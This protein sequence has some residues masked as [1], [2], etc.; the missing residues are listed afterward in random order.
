MTSIMPMTLGFTDAMASA[1]TGVG[2]ICGISMIRGTRDGMTPGI[3]VTA[4]AITAGTA[5]GTTAGA[6]P[7]IIGTMAIMDGAIL[8]MEVGAAAIIGQ[9]MTVTTA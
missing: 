9:A 8:T 7:I 1:H 6:I 3:M 5:R 4:T 2:A